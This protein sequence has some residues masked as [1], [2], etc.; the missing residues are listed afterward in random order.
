MSGPVDPGYGYPAIDTGVE[1]FLRLFFPQYF[2][3]NSPHYVEPTTL[4]ALALVANDA[5]P[6]CL[7]DTE[8]DLAQALFT[9]YLISVQQ[10]TSS[11]QTVTPKA[12]AITSEKEGDITVTYATTQTG[13]TTMSKRPAT[14]PWD[15]WNRLYMRCGRGAILTRFG[16]PCQQSLPSPLL[17]KTLVSRALQLT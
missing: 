12:G 4:T 15:A 11:G 14:D 13:T 17:T 9:A 6:W 2:D 16:D 7:S 8:Q 5:R 1:S 3:P 10:E